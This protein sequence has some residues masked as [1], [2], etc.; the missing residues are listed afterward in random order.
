MD[1]ISYPIIQPI[2]QASKQAINR[3][4]DRSINPYSARSL[5]VKQKSW[6]H[7]HNNLTKVDGLRDQCGETIYLSC[8]HSGRFWYFV[9]QNCGITE[10]KLSFSFSWL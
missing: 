6:D 3:S 7:D 9:A 2:N 4:I 5:S 1:R 10:R 8:I